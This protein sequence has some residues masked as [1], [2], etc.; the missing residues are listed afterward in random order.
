MTPRLLFACVAFCI[1]V[2]CT[3]RSSRSDLLIV[4][5]WSEPV[6]LNP[7]YLQGSDAA[8]IS[9]LGYSFLTSY[10]AR[11]AIIPDAAAIVPT[12]ENGGISRDGKRIIYHLRRDIRWQDGQPLTARDV[13]F[14]YRAIMNPSNAIQSRNGYDH[15]AGIWARCLYTVVVEL[16]RPQAGFVTGFFGGDSSY[17]ILPAHLLG[18]WP[19]LNHVSF[20]QLPIGSGP[21]RFTKWIRGERLDLTANDRYYGTK[22]AIRYIRMRFIPTTQRSSM[23]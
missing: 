20:N 18:V 2:G 17:P 19:N 1:A 23:S 16:K 22:P 15:I 3:N 11:D 7:L 10:D 8:D 4:A 6:S 21:Y 5:Q 13:V 14:T 12:S 9:A